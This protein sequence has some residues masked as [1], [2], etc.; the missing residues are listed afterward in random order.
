MST[1]VSIPGCSKPYVP[2]C[3]QCC[4]GGGS[5]VYPSC[6]KGRNIRE[7]PDSHRASVDEAFPMLRGLQLPWKLCGKH[8]A[9][10]SKLLPKQPTN[11][12]KK[13][14]R[15]ASPSTESSPA[16]DQEPIPAP[17]P[18][19]TTEVEQGSGT[20]GPTADTDAD[21]PRPTTRRRLDQAAAATAKVNHTPSP[22]CRH[23][24][25][26]VS[27]RLLYTTTHLVRVPSEPTPPV[28]VST[29]LRSGSLCPAVSCCASC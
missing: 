9:A 21:D 18:P 15:R 6:P 7:V 10:I 22:A 2:G 24:S 3:P 12:G 11:T 14:P 23:V 20:E 28:C 8:Q 13:R 25:Y 4:V 26:L 5:A 17:T 19:E 29:L 16:G 1:R 27:Q